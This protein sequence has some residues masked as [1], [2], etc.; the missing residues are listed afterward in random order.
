MGK[1]NAFGEALREIREK[2]DL[3]QQ[4]FGDM[5]EL[6]QVTVAQLES[7]RRGATHDTVNK[8]WVALGRDDGDWLCFHAGFL[9]PDMAGGGQK[10]RPWKGDVQ[11]AFAAY[12]KSLVLGFVGRRDV[13]SATS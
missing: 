8:L 1:D 7:G 10:W 9:P 5:C 2:L 13:G 6:G 12:R 4:A 3:T 11:D